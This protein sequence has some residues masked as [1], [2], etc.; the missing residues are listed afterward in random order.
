MNNV[1]VGT[2]PVYVEREVT[3]GFSVL[4]TN[5]TL[6]VFPYPNAPRKPQEI[7]PI[8]NEWKSSTKGVMAFLKP[9]VNVALQTSGS[10]RPVNETIEFSDGI[11]D[12]APKSFIEKSP[13]LRNLQAEKIIS[14]QL[15]DMIA[16]PQNAQ[17]R[18]VLNDPTGR[19]ALIAALEKLAS[20]LV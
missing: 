2:G 7:I 16:D 11:E 17:F 12:F 9:T 14:E 18:N 6:I 8:P 15:I 1:K 4:K 19:L 10:N 3:A 13:T 20:E 5:Q